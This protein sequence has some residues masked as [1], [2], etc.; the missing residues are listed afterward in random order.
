M[1]KVSVSPE[2][3]PYIHY[4]PS[5]TSG[6][7]ETNKEIITPIVRLGFDIIK[8]TG[9]NFGVN[10]SKSGANY[11]NKKVREIVKIA[12]IDRKVS[13]YDQEKHDNIYVPLYEEAS[14]K[15]ARKTHVDMMSRVQVNLYAAG[16]HREGGSAVNRYTQKEIKDH[17]ALMN[18][19][20]DQKPYKVD[21]HLNI[22][23]E[24][25]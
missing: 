11:Y 25:N 6:T 12:G 23:E 2:G 9:F 14:S 3:I 21:E 24:S 22:I 19:A 8:R 4:I 10:L 1:E 20:F 18:V 5:K 17:F 16:L 15:L 13:I 7:Q